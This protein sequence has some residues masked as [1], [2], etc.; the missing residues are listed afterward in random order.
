MTN[1]TFEMSEYKNLQIKKQTLYSDYY[2][3][4]IQSEYK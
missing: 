3:T 2:R 4:K 1:I